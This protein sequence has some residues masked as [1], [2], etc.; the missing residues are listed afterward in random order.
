MADPCGI[1][2]V[3]GVVG[4]IIQATVQFGLDWKDAPADAKSFISE[5]QVLKTV[6]SETNTNITLYREFA[7]AFHGR[8][9]SLVS[10]PDAAA[11][12]KDTRLMVLAC[13]AGLESLLEDLKKRARGHRI[14]WERLKGAFLA[15]NTREAV[16]NLH[17]QCQ[18]LNGLVG[19]NALAVGVGTY[20]EVK[21]ARKEQQDWHEAEESKV[22]LDW[23]TRIDYYSQQND[24]INRRQAETGQWLLDSEQFEAWEGTEE[25]TLFCP[26]IPG[27]GKTILTS[28]VIDTLTTSQDNTV[29]LTPIVA[30]DARMIRAPSVSWQASSSSWPAHGR[31]F[32][33]RS[34]LSTTVTRASSHDR[35]SKTSHRP[36][37]LWPR[38]TLGCSSLLTHLTDAKQ[39]V[40]GASCRRSSNFRT[41]AGRISSPHQDSSR[42]LSKNSRDTQPLRFVQ[43][44]RT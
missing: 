15:K 1:I 10:W 26:G 37:T 39:L 19:I 20:K 40:G 3:I 21:E 28:I 7:N 23:L 9:S 5:L 8:Q 43:A 42:K 32:P 11:Q 16:E 44:E 14:G 34:S 4:Q 33:M 17:R 27:A 31:I 6:I 24:F 30:S 25:R 41:I 13:Q 12:K 35:P 18:V 22:I 36:S 2:G 29:S 38:H